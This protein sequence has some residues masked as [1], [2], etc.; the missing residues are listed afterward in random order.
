MNEVE[1]VRWSGLWRKGETVRV[2]IRLAD[3]RDA[4]LTAFWGNRAGE[5][6]IEYGLVISGVD[7]TEDFII[8]ADL[9]RAIE[10]R[11]TGKRGDGSV[12]LKDLHLF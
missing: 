6:A 8:P 10:Q 5:P 11:L 7:Y 12:T 9:E 4:L 2:G 1:I 3:G